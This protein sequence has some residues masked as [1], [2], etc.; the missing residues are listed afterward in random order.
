MAPLL[1]LAD[2]Y[3][4]LNDR[5]KQKRTLERLIALQSWYLGESHR[6]VAFTAFE[7]ALVFKALDERPTALTLVER[8][9]P[10]FEREFGVNHPHAD[11]ARRTAAKLRKRAW[12]PFGKKPAVSA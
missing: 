4:R 7:L 2:T 1:A 3:R 5:A 6:D 10:I 9:V 8:A 12:R 11:Q